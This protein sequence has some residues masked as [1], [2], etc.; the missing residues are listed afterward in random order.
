[1][2]N[3]K[4]ALRELKEESESGEAVAVRAAST[5]RG[6][7]RVLLAIGAA[8]LLG[9]AGSVAVIM[10]RGRSE[11]PVP[12]PTP[13]RAVPLTTYEGRE[14][15]PTLSPDGNSVA[16]AWDGENEDNW[17]I[18]IKLTLRVDHRAD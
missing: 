16:F 1:M 9:I 3:V 2:A 10:W 5:R 12:S 14:Q 18:Y 11:E 17:D 8:M 13:V 6:M 15:Q 7:P 4:I